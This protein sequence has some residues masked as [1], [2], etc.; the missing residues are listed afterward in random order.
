MQV[1]SNNW[2][3]PLAAGQEGNRDSFSNYKEL[4]AAS[5]LREEG[6]RLSPEPPERSTES[7][8]DTLILA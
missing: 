4:N 7:I 6:N 1:A 5:H 8:A 2:K 3:Q